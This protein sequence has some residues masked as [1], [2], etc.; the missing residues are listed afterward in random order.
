MDALATDTISTQRPISRRRR[1]ARRG[2]MPMAYAGL[3]LFTIVYF[4]R[5]GDWIPALSTIPLAK[6]S[7]AVAVLSFVFSAIAVR[8]NFRIS[9]EAILLVALFSQFCL[10]VPFAYFRTG[11]FWVVFG[12]FLKILVIVLSLMFA[13]NSIQRLVKLLSFQTAAMAIMAAV[14][15]SS[16]RGGRAEGVVGGDFNN[17]NDFALSVVLVLPLAFTFFIS[18]RGFVRRAIW[19]L[20]FALLCYAVLITYSRTGFLALIAAAIAGIFQY[21]HEF[22]ERPL[23]VVGI[24]ITAITLIALGPVNYWHRTATIFHPEEDETGSAQQRE[25]LL[26][27]SVTLT[28]ENPVLGVGPGNFAALSGVWRVTH[29]TYTELSCE[30]GIPALVLFLWLLLRTFK[31]LDKVRKTTNA[32]SSPHLLASGIRTSMW[33]LIVGAFFTSLTYHFFPYFLIAYAVALENIVSIKSTAIP[34]ANCKTLSGQVPIF[35]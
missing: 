13:V 19:A 31:N 14:S 11:S 15:A 34:D 8:G 21:R 25:F 2:F 6:I 23:L 33:A 24:G 20:A 7:G 35:L 10:S 30:A 27:R 4:G 28:L 16:Y 32:G 29:N 12:V 1:L 3:L 18:S 26:R 5:P 17:P 9:R 22:I